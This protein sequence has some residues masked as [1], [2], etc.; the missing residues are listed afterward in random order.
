MITSC[1]IRHLCKIC[2][3]PNNRQLS[4]CP[5]LS[6]HLNIWP[7]P[8][9]IFGTPT[10]FVENCLLS[11]FPSLSPHL[12][13]YQIVGGFLL[14]SPFSQICHVCENRQLSIWLFCC[15]IVSIL[16]KLAAFAKYVIFVKPTIIDMPLLSSCSNFLQT[17]NINFFQICHFRKI[18]ICQDAPFLLSHLNIWPKPRWIFGTLAIFAE[19]CL[20][21]LNLPLCY[22][23][24]HL[25]RFPSLS[26]QLRFCQTFDGFLPNS[27]FS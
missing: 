22:Y 27:P 8:W 13:F 14:N 7:N 11:I 5:F 3:C 2:H 16:A 4:T 15:L 12:R 26:L 23:D 25:S 24:R 10:I 9:C 21:L 6:S 1:Q 20:F 18:A 19:I 17:L